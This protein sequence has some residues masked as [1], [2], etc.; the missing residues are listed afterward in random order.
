L[1]AKTAKLR[2]K[3]WEKEK[4]LRNQI[5]FEKIEEDLDFHYKQ[6]SKG[7]TSIE[8]DL[9]LKTLEVECNKHILAEEEL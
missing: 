4:R 8:L 7:L 1:E 9:R 6:R 3:T 2:V 5:A